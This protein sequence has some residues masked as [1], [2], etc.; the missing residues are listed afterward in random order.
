MVSNNSCTK[1]KGGE[2]E[3][4]EAG[5]QGVEHARKERDWRML[6]S[7]QRITTDRDM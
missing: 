3:A 2:D 6:A 5:A 1:D 7:P 4:G